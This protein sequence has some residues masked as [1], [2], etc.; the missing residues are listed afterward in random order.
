MT[1]VGLI[2]CAREEI[3]SAP[4]LLSFYKPSFPSDT[5]P[6]V[7]CK[8]VGALLYSFFPH[9]LLFFR[10]PFFLNQRKPPPYCELLLAQSTLV[11]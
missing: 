5:S 6:Q 2:A 11:L 3:A 8:G 1:H 10:K 9:P 7:L 4:L